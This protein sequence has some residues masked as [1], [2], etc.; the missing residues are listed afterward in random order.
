VD[1]R[2]SVLEAQEMFLD[3]MRY[4]GRQVSKPA[5]KAVMAEVGRRVGRSLRALNKRKVEYAIDLWGS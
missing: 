1:K 3:A 2:E 4:M 5:K